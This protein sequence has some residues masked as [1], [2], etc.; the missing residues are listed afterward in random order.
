ME[1]E[2][3]NVKRYRYKISIIIFVLNV[4]SVIVSYF[5]IYSGL[6]IGPM[7]VMTFISFG[8]FVSDNRADKESDLWNVFYVGGSKRVIIIALI[9]FLYFFVS[10]FVSIAVL[11]NGNP[12]IIDGTYY[13]S[14][15]GIIVNQI[16]RSEY[17][18]LFFAERRLFSAG[19]LPFSAIALAYW[20]SSFKRNKKT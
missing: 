19:L 4:I 1:K 9:C 11:Q 12:T 18:K 7:F 15:K 10:F 8:T 20:S 5:W 13:L 16:G 14:N 17:Y 3:V 2:N 6:I